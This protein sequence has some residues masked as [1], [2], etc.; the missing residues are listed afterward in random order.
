[1]ED[2]EKKSLT[3]S[4]ASSSSSSSSNSNIDDKTTS[5]LRKRIVVMGGTGRQGGATA[6]RLLELGCFDVIVLSRQPPDSLDCKDLI[7]KGFQTV[8]AN[9]LDLAS[10]KRAFTGAWGVYGVTNPFTG[11][12]WTGSGIK[13]TTDT[14][15]EVQQGK[16]IADAARFCGVKL[17]IFASAASALESTGVATMEAKAN[18]ERYIQ[19]LDSLPCA[20]LCPVGFYENML[21]PFAGLKQFYIPGL[22]KR[23][24]PV[25][26]VSLDDIGYFAGMMFNDPEKWAGK[27]LEIAGDEI[28]SEDIARVIGKV[29]NEEGKWKIVTLPGWVFSMFVPAAVANVRTFLEERGAHVNIAELRRDLHP[30]LQDFETWCK[31]KGLDKRVFPQPSSL[32][33]IV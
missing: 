10:L 14:N 1:M 23:D 21:S 32:C 24:R 19:T 7:S 20:I 4:S 17:L 12:R 11:A 31:V 22:V 3:V 13:P 6:R 18:V 2:S 15:A 28:S 8:Q 16:N 33:S 26:M 27:R 5:S 25:Q 9:A 29:R 30:G